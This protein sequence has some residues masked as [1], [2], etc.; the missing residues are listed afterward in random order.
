MKTTSEAFSTIAEA[1]ILGQLA[2]SEESQ[3]QHHLPETE[4]TCSVA[5]SKVPTEGVERKLELIYA[6]F[7]DILTLG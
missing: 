5:G 6:G 1:Y 2:Q 3:A 7:G 4:D